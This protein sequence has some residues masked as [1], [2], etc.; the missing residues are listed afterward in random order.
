MA[1]PSGPQ[2]PGQP[3]CPPGTIY[4]HEAKRCRSVFSK[5]GRKIKQM[6]KKLR[7]KE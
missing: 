3:K 6:F 5:V 1:H 4:D 7:G 2:L